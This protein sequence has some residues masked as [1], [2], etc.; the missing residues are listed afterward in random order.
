MRRVSW[1]LA[2]RRS[3]VCAAGPAT[4]SSTST[5]RCRWRCSVGRRNA[6]VPRV[7]LTTSTR[8]AAVGEE[9]PA[10]AEGFSGW[11]ARRSDRVVAISN[12]TA[13]SCAT[14]RRAHRGHSLHDV[15]Q[16]GRDVPAPGRQVPC[17][18]WAGWWS[19]GVAHLIEAIARLGSRARLEIVGEG[20]ERPGLEALAGGWRWRIGWCSEG[21][22][23]DELQASYA[24]A[25]VCVC[26]SARRPRRHRRARRRAARGDEPRDSGDRNRVGGIRTSWR[27]ACRACSFRRET[28]LRWRQRC[29]ECATTRPGRGS[30]RAVGAGCASSSLA[31]IVRVLDLYAGLVTTPR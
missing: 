19:A 1:S 2:W 10:V 26:V 3:G 18:S 14:C 21:R 12:Y 5:G 13:A 25:A 8:G 20:P 11:A 17:C 27:T 22:S 4:M 30:G 9:R 31:G 7:W 23:A 6:P 16:S 29:G 24:R 28:S 15:V